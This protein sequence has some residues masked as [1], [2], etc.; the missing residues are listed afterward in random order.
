MYDDELRAFLIKAKANT[1]AA[2][3]GSVEPGRPGCKDL[4]YAEGPYEYLDSYAGERDFSGQELV[5]R[6][7]RVIWSMNYYG[8][9][10][11]DGL[12]EGFIETLREALKLATVAEPYRGPRSYDRAPY[13]Y[14]SA[15]Q[16]ELTMYNGMEE[17]Y[18]AGE[19]VYRLYFH[20]GEVR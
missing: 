1:Y 3:R 17:I 2:Q 19:A 18:L 10:L 5:Y 7:G 13:S 20:G 14:K 4:R 6:D 11:A 15:V 8:A 9:M 16:G 12:P